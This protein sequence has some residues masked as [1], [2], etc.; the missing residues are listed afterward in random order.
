MPSTL[1]IR[2]QLEYVQQQVVEQDFPEKLMAAGTIL[3]ISTEIPRGAET[4]AYRI[5]TFLGEAAILA[6]GADD[7]PLVNAYAE[8]RSGFIR[9]FV[10]GYEYTIED[11]E[12]AE[13]AGM[14]LDA[15]MAIAAREVLETKFDLTGYD[16]DANFNLLGLIGHPNVPSYTIP[17][18]GAGAATAWA[19]KTADQIYRDLRNFAS[20][21]R[22]AT[23]G[24]ENPQVIIMPIAQFDLIAGMPYPTADASDTI[25]SFFLKT[26]RMTPQGVQT[27]LP[28]AYLAG[29]GAGSTD[30]MISYTKR[31][32]KV[33]LH[34][35]LDF[36]MEPVQV[37]NFSY[38]VPCRMRS[39]GV[40]V[41]KPL[42]IRYAIGI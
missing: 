14:N 41:N 17:N 40:Q 31:Q 6:N 32:D 22:I 19:T 18:D 35:P 16:G 36:T 11:M 28:V 29:K 20:A 15:Q 34:M 33:K 8:K 7:I 42:S 23:N 13:F 21:T 9:T 5:L 26:Q 2:D 24:I 38:R 12:S 39:G 1:F 4:Y 37:R 10:D 30:L 25:L 3:D 27:V